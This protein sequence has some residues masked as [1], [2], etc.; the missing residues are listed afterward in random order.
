MKIEV[1]YPEICSLYGELG[2][3]DYIKK[4]MPDCEIVETHINDKPA[5]IDGNIDLVYMGTMTESSQELVLEKLFPLKKEISDAIENGQRFLITG[6]AVE[7]FGKEIEDVD[8][9]LVENGKD[10]VECLGIFEFSTKR[11]MLHRFNSLYVG[12]Y[13]GLDIVGFKSQFSH[14]YYEDRKKLRPFLNTTIGT[15]FNPDIKEEGIHYKNFIGTYLIGPLLVL[16]PYFFIK[17]FE[18]MGCKNVKPAYFEQA[19]SAY[20][21]RLKEYTTPGK[22]LYY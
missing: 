11:R 3:I 17:F 14:S 16:N 20:D 7:I 21:F 22:G 1:M 15:G 2:N 9:A 4:S 5:F 6:N 10:A 18:D 8:K 12:K 13:E 19:V